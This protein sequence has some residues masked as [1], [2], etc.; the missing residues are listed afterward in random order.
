MFDLIVH[1][2][3]VID[4]T[5]APRFRADV[6][7]RGG[8]IAAVD[9]LQAAEARRRID[10]TGRIVAP[11]FIDVHNH[12]EGWLLR[13]P[14]F[15]PKTSQGFTAEVLQADGIGYAPVDERTW[16]AWIYY[17]LGL[18][19]LRLDEYRGWRSIGEFLDCIAGRTVQ[20]AA[21]HVPYANVR[22]L[23]C[24]WGARQV[25][26]FQM[27]SIQAEIRRGMEEG[28]VGLSTGLDYI[29]QCYASTDELVEACRALVPYDGL[30]VT[31]VRYKRGLLPA[32][33]EA[34][35][36]GRR[37]GVRVHISHLKAVTPNEPEPVL[38]FL[39]GA[40][41]DVDLSF[42]VYPYQ[43][44]SSVLSAL[45]PYE[46]WQEGP[47]AALHYLGRDD[48]RQR[49]G[50][51]LQAYRLPLDRIRLAWVPGKD[52]S[53]HQGKMLSQYVADMGRNAA[54]ALADL[55]IE[56]R[57]A[58]LVVFLDGEDRKSH[59][60][61]KHDLA[62]LGSDGIYQ[63]G[64]CVHPRVYGSAPRLLGPLVRDQRL[65][66]LEEAVRKCSGAAARRF[67]LPDRGEIRTGACADLVVFDPDT[68]ADRAT[69]DQPHQVCT[70]V[71][72]VIVQGVPVVDHGQAVAVD[73]PLPGQRLRTR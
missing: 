51:G 39:E 8:R 12:S 15:L 26:D 53:A 49:F 7:I 22:V 24:G 68:I 3:T 70:G 10:A 73:G 11:G 48:V 27:R 55:L 56:E 30:Y 13:Q 57:L 44:G 64:G 50:D 58:P 33:Q 69:Y 25:D 47:L 46:V 72:H 6:G 38:E 36:I 18:D 29:D 19:A 41:R 60:F 32:L 43:A 67:K 17:L 61:L 65:L 34:V 9:L 23:A 5:G 14:N 52:N 35:E 62:M 20:H 59:P 37:A 16:R 28:A 42:D 40:R 31:H 45:L 2:G 71:D 1:G 4:G 54:D 63:Q 21:A 66:S